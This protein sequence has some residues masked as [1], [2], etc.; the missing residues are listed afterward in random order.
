MTTDHVPK[1]AA[2]AWHEGDKRYVV[3]GIAKGSGMISPVDGDDALVHRHRCA[4]VARRLAR[5]AC[6]KR[7]TA[8]ST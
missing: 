3:G 8:A 4:D 5:C 2:Y 7:P 1:M 6:A